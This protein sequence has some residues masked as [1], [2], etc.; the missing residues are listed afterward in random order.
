MPISLTAKLISEAHEN[1]AEYTLPQ[2]F[3]IFELPT[4]DSTLGKVKRIEE[5]L[6]QWNLNLRPS[7]N[8]GEIELAR[9]VCFATPAPI[10]VGAAIDE[11]RGGEGEQLEFKSSLHYDYNKAKH[12]PNASIHELSSAG[13]LHSCL[14]TIAAFSNSEGGTLYIGVDDAGAI[15]GIEQDYPCISPIAAKQNFDNWELS[16]R[17]HVKGHFLEGGMVNDFVDVTCLKIEGR[18]VARAHISV[19]RR[20]SFLRTQGAPALFRRQGNRTEQVQIHEMEEFLIARGWK[21]PS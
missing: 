14:K 3:D 6:A 5:F 15:L 18:A 7:L 8:S 20:L 19:R 4:A 1:R 13:V 11:I 17:D 12:N 10:N 2:L 21:A 16:L 9:R